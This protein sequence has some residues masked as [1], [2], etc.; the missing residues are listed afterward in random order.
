MAFTQA[1][2]TALESAIATGA[3][4]VRYAD[5]DVQYRDL[6]EMEKLLAKMKRQVNGTTR[7]RLVRVNSV[8][9]FQR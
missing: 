7:L 6:D 5:R 8:K 4:R 3:T 1:Q 2:I 9:G